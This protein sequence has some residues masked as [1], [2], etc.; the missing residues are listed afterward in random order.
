MHSR[1]SRA[2]WVLA[3]LMCASVASAQLPPSLVYQEV[4]SFGDGLYA[5]RQNAYRSIF[6]VTDDGVI[7]TDPVSKVYASAYRAE[8]AKITDK[9]V[10][11]V[12]Y[13]QSQ[14]DRTRGGKI[15]KDEGATFIAHEKCLENLENVPHPEAVMPEIT[16]S[17]EYSVELGNHSLDLYYFGP[18]HDTC[19]S[20]MVA[21]P[22]NIMFVTNVVNPPVATNPWNPTLANNYPHNYISFFKAAEA[23]AEREQIDTL[24]GGFMSIG[25]G[26]DRKPMVL[27]GSG[28][29]TVLREQRIYWE[30]VMNAV[31]AALDAGVPPKQ[32]IDKIDLEPFSSY[33]FYSKRNM[34]VVFRRVASLYITGR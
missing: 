13:S 26:P 14:W 16:Y 9:P 24:I 28:P 21:K 5:F 22:A 6:I 15:F 27:P 1:V 4:E 32:L 8:I 25:L 34:N 12:V 17:A 30:T 7:V 3:G 2:A 23:L 11:Y 33:Q 10:R 31:K 18:A 29:I 19:L 20:V